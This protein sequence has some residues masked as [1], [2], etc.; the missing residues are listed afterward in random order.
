GHRRRTNTFKETTWC[1]NRW[2][3]R[4]AQKR[5]DDCRRIFTGL[6]ELHARG[7]TSDQGGHHHINQI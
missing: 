5:R 2:N 3:A 1:Y 4:R 7:E 6:T